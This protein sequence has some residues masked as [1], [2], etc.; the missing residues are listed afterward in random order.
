MPQYL[1]TDPN[2]GAETPRYLSTDPMAGQG[3]EAVEPNEPD[4][5]LGG[6]GKGLKE[7]FAPGAMLERGLQGA[8]GVVRGATD[9][10]NP[11]TYLETAQA[12][13]G[14]VKGAA[15]L[16]GR[17]ANEGVGPVLKGAGRA[18]EALASDPYSVGRIVGSAASPTVAGTTANAVKSIPATRLLKTGAAATGGG[19][20]NLPIVGG[21][22]RGAIRAGRRA[23]KDSAPKPPGLRTGPA[24]QPAIEP[25]MAPMDASGRA[26][27]GYAGP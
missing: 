27:G 9:L 20:A 13:P 26:L 23:W 5:W 7:Q 21:P 18:V 25:A 19:L 3:D 17:I 24:A 14:F 4:T 22:V 1:S 11:L 16:P 12:I 8:R 6:Y 10:I 2:A 15:A